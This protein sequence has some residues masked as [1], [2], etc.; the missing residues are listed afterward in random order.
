MRKKFLVTFFCKG[1]TV[2]IFLKFSPV[3]RQYISVNGQTERNS[4]KLLF[5]QEL[6]KASWQ[7]GCTTENVQSVVGRVWVNNHIAE[8]PVHL[9]H[10]MSR[11]GEAKSQKKNFENGW[12]SQNETSRDRNE[13]Q[14]DHWNLSIREQNS[15]VKNRVRNATDWSDW[16]GRLCRSAWWRFPFHLHALGQWSRS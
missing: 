12:Q 4:N 6:S 5:R 16:V 15:K 1:H 3:V 7:I 2:P 14:R 10:L 13:V 11:W 9:S 8:Q